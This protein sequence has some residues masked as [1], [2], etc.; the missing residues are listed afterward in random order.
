MKGYDIIDI[1]SLKDA[2][3]GES[4]IVPDIN[5]LEDLDE[6]LLKGKVTINDFSEEELKSAFRTIDESRLNR[7]YDKLKDIEL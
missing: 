4:E 1:E 3:E 6:W 2:M 7:N 5:S